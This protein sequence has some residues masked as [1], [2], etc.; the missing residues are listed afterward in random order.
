MRTTN[1]SIDSAQETVSMETFTIAC[2][3]RSKYLAWYISL[4]ATTHLQQ[5]GLGKKADAC[6]NLGF[7]NSGVT[8]YKLSC[9]AW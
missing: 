7:I 5:Q 9:V 6:F 2:Y 8:K 4:G 1:C 3:V